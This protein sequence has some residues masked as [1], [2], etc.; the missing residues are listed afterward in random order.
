MFL[1]RKGW[2]PFSYT[3]PHHSKLDHL[4]RY[5]SG[6][7]R[8][9][10]TFDPFNERNASSIPHQSF[11]ISPTAILS[12]ICWKVEDC[13]HVDTHMPPFPFSICL[14]KN[15][16]PFTPETQQLMMNCRVT[17]TTLSLSIALSNTN[18]SVDEFTQNQHLSTLIV[19]PLSYLFF[20][21]YSLLSVCGPPC[22][23]LFL[24]KANSTSTGQLDKLVS[25]GV[26]ALTPESEGEHS[27]PPQRVSTFRPRPYS[28][29]DS[30]KVRNMKGQRSEWMCLTPTLRA[31]GRDSA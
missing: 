13:F 20:L 26:P 6:E 9:F 15:Q 7:R 17:L 28:M 24:S 25:G 10:L 27:L 29:A 5:D 31:N 19:F 16:T 23:S 4:E 30:N 8:L 18:S 22:S 14:P 3:Q 21:V 2:F 1:H 12:V 11:K